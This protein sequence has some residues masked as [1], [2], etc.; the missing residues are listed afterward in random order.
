MVWNVTGPISARLLALF[1][2]A[3]G[4]CA[5]WAAQQPAEAWQTH[6][7]KSDIRWTPAISP[8]ILSRFQRLWAR[9]DIRVDGQ[10]FADR[11][12][13]RQLVTWVELTDSRGNAHSAYGKIDLQK[14]SQTPSVRQVAYGIDVFLLP[15]TYRVT[16]AVIEPS[17]GKYSLTRRTLR[18]S[19]IRGDPLEDAWRDLPPVEF[20]TLPDPPDLWFLPEDDSRLHLPLENRRPVRVEIVV[21]TSPSEHSH[22]PERSREV[23]MQTVLPLVKAVSQIG[24]AHGSVNVT[25][26]DIS[27]HRLAFRQEGVREVDWPGLK[28]AL[29]R[30]N[31]NE[32]DVA[33]LKERN[34][35]A[36]FFLGEIARRLDPAPEV[37]VAI[38][39]SAPLAFAAPQQTESP[40]PLD[41]DAHLFYIRL[42]APIRAATG[43]GPPEARG[44]W[45]TPPRIP[46]MAVPSPL[47]DD[48]LDRMLKAWRP[49]RFDV[50]TPMEQRKALAE[51]MRAIAGFCR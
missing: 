48:E 49:R 22:R 16:L 29:A 17:T 41:P 31:P 14:F 5:A 13:K 50:S 2:P 38:I 40:A 36:Q 35:S 42:R 1:L 26:L 24:L 30:D 12:R 32:I 46:T 43:G 11:K 20:L 47:G 15:D 3:A 19:P 21:N 18:V 8:V 33:E 6:V 34:R 51:I 37:R 7:E 25:F 27:R 28:A 10:E 44:R 23:A 39:L 4:S 45:T 9:I